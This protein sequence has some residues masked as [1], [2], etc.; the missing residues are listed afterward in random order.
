MKHWLRNMAI[1]MLGMVSL[2]SCHDIPF[3]C[4]YESIENHSWEKRD[5]ITFCLPETEVEKSVDMTV[6]MRTLADFQYSK[7][8]VKAELCTE[9]GNVLDCDTVVIPLFSK[10][11]NALGKGFPYIESS[12]Q[13]KSFLLKPHQAYRI[14]LTHIMRL[15]NLDGIYNIGIT[16]E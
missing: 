15:Y 16:L 8:S 9:E 4:V 1:G 10:N 12:K 6:G 7:V 5:T 14:R 3:F 2:V 13:S 11:G